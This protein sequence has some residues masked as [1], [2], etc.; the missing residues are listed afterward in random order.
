MIHLNKIK[1]LISQTFSQKCWS[2]LVWLTLHERTIFY[3]LAVSFHSPNQDINLS[4]IKQLKSIPGCSL[5]WRMYR[6]ERNMKLQCSFLFIKYFAT[7]YK[8]T[9]YSMLILIFSQLASATFVIDQCNT[10]FMEQMLKC[11]NKNYTPSENLLQ[12]TQ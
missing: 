4:N 6:E 7:G 12:N 1:I 3:Y 9:K 11:T 10:Q 2:N 8:V 5:E